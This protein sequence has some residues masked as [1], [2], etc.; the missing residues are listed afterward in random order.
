MKYAALNQKHPTYDAAD[1]AKYQALYEG[2]PSFHAAH[3]LPKNPAEEDTSYAMRCASAQYTNYIG[4]ILDW[5]AA[6]LMAAP[7][8][9]RPQDKDAEPPPYYA[10]WKEDVDGVGTDLVD[11]M[12][13]RF[14]GACVKRLA[15]WAIE[16]PA[17]DEEQPAE[18]LAMWEERGLGNARLVTFDRDQ[19]LD[20]HTD[21]RGELQWVIVHSA[22]RPRADPESSRDAVMERWRIYDREKVTTYEVTYTEK[23]PPRPEDEI[24]M[25]SQ[26]PHIF[27]RVPVVAMGFDGTRPTHVKIGARKVSMSPSAVRGMWPMGRLASIQVA[28]FRQEAGLEWSIARTCYAMPVFRGMDDK[29]PP[30]MGAGYYIQIGTSESFDWTAPPTAHLAIAAQRVD[31]RRDE[32]YRVAN[33]LSQGVDNNAAAIGRSGE[34]KLADAENTKV[35]LAIFGALVR[36]AVE[37]TID[38]VSRGRGEAIRWSVQ[39]LDKFDITDA[40]VLVA[41]AIQAQ[42]LAI[43]SRTATVELKYR[44]AIA[45]LPGLTEPTRQIIRKEIEDGTNAEEAMRVREV[46]EAADREEPDDVTATPA[47][48]QG[49]AEPPAP[50]PRGTVAKRAPVEAADGG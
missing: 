19:I 40:S 20:W 11:F 46:D 42:A 45:M 6:A 33:Q 12:R 32:I 47:E 25:V 26:R 10:A 34:S 43:P 2:G 50:A 28:H 3:F 4:P 16:M 23:D 37:K 13:E 48:G 30:R 22:D 8:D 17:D 29:A 38:L 27:G 44:S 41:T 36:E 1:W 35:I 7:L 9:I 31:S 49:Q 21:D 14:V 15:W 24:P 39:G 5:F 18:N